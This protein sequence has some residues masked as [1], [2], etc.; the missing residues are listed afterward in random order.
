M[1]YIIYNIFVSLQILVDMIH[2]KNLIS[3]VLRR[4]YSSCVVRIALDEPNLTANDEE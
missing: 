1:Y 3:R 4:I 2:H